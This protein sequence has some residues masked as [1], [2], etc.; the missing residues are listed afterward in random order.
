MGTHTVG[1]ETSLGPETHVH[2]IINV[3]VVYM[4]L[5]LKDFDAGKSITRTIGRG[6]GPEI[7]TF[8]GPNGIAILGPK[9]SISGPTPSMALLMILAVSKSV[10]S[11]LYKQ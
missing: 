3:P 2:K 7:S 5:E 4:A 10:R 8:L 11:A 6:V 1:W 9:V